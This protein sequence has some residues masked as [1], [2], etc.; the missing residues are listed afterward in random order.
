MI[1]L[2]VNGLRLQ[3]KRK[4]L[5]HNLRQHNPDI[6]LLQETH[7]TVEN[8]KIWT[9]EWGGNAY[10]NHGR[11]NSRGVCILFKR[12]FKPKIELLKKD[13][14]GRLLI[15]QF[16]NGSDSL[17]VVNVYAPTQSENREQLH[18]IELLDE[19][20]S[21]IEI[22]SLFLGGDFNIQLEPPATDLSSSPPSGTARTSY[23]NQIQ[24]LLDDYNLEDLWKAKNPL[25]KRG[26][27][28]RRSYSARLD[29]WFIPRHLILQSTSIKIIPHALS[30]HCLLVMEIKFHPSEKGPGYWKF[31][32]QLLTE[33][34]F[35]AK[36]TTHIQGALEEDLS[37]PNALWEW[38]KFKIRSFS[39]KYTIES[40][41]ERR[42]TISAMEDRLNFLAT[43]HDLT[44]DSDIV[45]EVQSL[46]RE[47]GEIYKSKATAAAFR[48]KVNWSMH[49][50]CPS[51]YYLGL[52][53]RAAKNKTISSLRSESG[54]L[55]TSNAEILKIEKEYFA[56]IYTEDPSSLASLDNLDLNRDDVPTISD[57]SRVF[58][59]RPFSE[60][61]F[62]SALKQLNHNKAPGSDG[63]TPEFYHA[64][65]DVLRHP[66][67]ESFN[68][69]LLQGKFSEEQ[70]VGVITLIPKKDQDRQVISN[71]RPIT[72]LNSDS[73]IV[74]KAL[75]TR[76]QSCIKEVVSE[77][78]TGFIRGRSITTNLLNIQSLIEKADVDDQPGFLLAVDF[79]KAFNTVR[80]QLIFKALELFG[81]GE[82]ILDMVKMLFTDIKT[83]IYNAGFSSGFFFPSRGIR[84]G[85]C[86][87]PSLFILASEL[88]AIMVRNS[89][90]IKGI[91]IGDKKVVISQYADDSTFFVQ[92]ATSIVEL[93]ALLNDFA[94]FS[95]LKVNASKT[96]LLLLG[97]H[98]HPPAEVQGIKVVETIR[99]LGIHFKNRISDE[100]MYNL[101]YKTP[102]N[103]IRQI[104]LNWINRS[105]SFK[106][107]VTLINA[108]MISTLQ[109]VAACT[110]VP[111][112]AQIEYKK[113]ATD[114]FWN[115]AR[116]KVSYN[117]II[118]KIEDGGLRLADLPTRISTSRLSLV[119]Q[120]WHKPDSI[121]VTILAQALKTEDLR[122]AL[123]YK[124]DLS[125]RIDP[126]FKLLSNV[127]SEWAK[128]HIRPPENEQEV[129]HELLWN[130]SY[131][132]INK[133]ALLWQ[134]WDSAGIHRINDLLH[135]TQP[136][137]LSHE[138]INTRFG[139][140]SSFIQILQIRSA[141]PVAWK[142]LLTNPALP[143]IPPPTSLPTKMPDSSIL[144]L[145]RHSPKKVYNS[146]LLGKIPMVSSQAKWT[147][148]LGLEL[149]DHAT[150]WQEVYKSPYRATRDTK[151]QAFQFRISHRFLP[152]N[153]FLCNI[154]IRQD[155]TCSFCDRQD[156]VQHF[157]FECQRV[158][159][160]WST[161]RQWL[162]QE[163]DFHIH[164]NMLEFIFGVPQGIPQARN[165]NFITLTVKFFI[166]RQNLYHQGALP[167]PQFL[168][169]FRSKLLV[170][171]RICQLQG[172]PHMF[173]SWE[174]ILAALG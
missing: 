50:E 46:K 19:L 27:F 65:W 129:Q 139:L 120:I 86:S 124:I 20:L 57:L 173:R 5:F 160:F 158:Q 74:S 84:Q 148:T 128:V 18:M 58:I 95:G 82:L 90:K 77:D 135:H 167:L 172:K 100:E 15:L 22:Q 12:D 48:S 68:Y 24:A 3:S 106:G 41:R 67:M 118:Q 162:A 42:K 166:Y 2:N 152:C 116:S 107:K 91:P 138:E 150:F 76:L 98:K 45:S 92:N 141:I 6:V 28:H 112:R 155:D 7:S 34:D 101:N 78:Q 151:L 39:I 104:C 114:F 174:K 125:R 70:R 71:W 60:D 44:S 64:F 137:F 133:V 53:K 88:L 121:W 134:N 52:E 47:L 102:L 69:S 38:I 37:N 171:K 93:L 56:K 23:V 132:T 73:K 110:S 149:E 59:N 40:N 169:E 54:V 123:L 1:T 117:L 144:D 115:S 8:E 168:H 113:I 17:T 109:Y 97:N 170:E 83:C 43:E 80:W 122:M 156:T 145:T 75:A 51:A 136:R 36:M 10:Y 81:F 163:A 62:F 63:I 143:A 79:Q 55:V 66:F 30:D 72:L 25:S 159:T 26:T 21:N 165:I 126:R 130:N 142:R 147:D 32:N 9:S 164:T 31:N 154:R 94:A 153:K 127:L 140:N 14:E 33:P 96:Y 105:M 89:P 99:I 103:K 157:L 161:L 61:E 131:I 35:V 111:L 119:R 108:L 49:G 4:A 29:Y 87:S 16:K 85:C 13:Q 146:L 11:S